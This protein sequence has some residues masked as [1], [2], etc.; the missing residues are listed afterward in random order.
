MPAAAPSPIELRKPAELTAHA[1]AAR[2]PVMAEGDYGAFRA[3]V[4]ERGV[5]V[6]LEVTEAGVLLDGRQRLRA[7]CEL[8][9]ATVPVMIVAPAD[10]LDYMLRAAVLRR[11]LTASQRAALAVEL[12]AYDELRSQARERQRANLEK[13]PEVAALPP[14]GKTREEAARWASV[15]PRVVQDVATVR[16]HDA[17]LFERVKR[18]EVAA[19]LAARRVRRALR[20]LEKSVPLPAGPFELVYADP[21]WQLGHPDGPHAPERHYPTMP[22]EEIKALELPAADEAVLF[23][24]R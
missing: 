12:R 10:E 24:G 22:L 7:A 16:E 13:N 17:E 18:G 4:E 20:D 14:R 15:S 6:P 5:R 2:I 11:Q 8:A 1:D 21:P 19:G 3:D 9:L 23:P